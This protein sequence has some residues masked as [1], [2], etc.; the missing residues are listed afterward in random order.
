MFK[1]FASSL[2]LASILIFSGFANIT[3]SPGD[4]GTE[5]IVIGTVH[6]ATDNYNEDTLISILENIKPDII[7]V[8][9]DTSYMTTAF[10]FKESIK[11]ISLETKAITRYQASTPVELRPYDIVNRDAFLDDYNRRNQERNFFREVEQLYSAGSLSPEALA[12]MER[13]LNMMEIAEHM[14]NAAPSYINRADGSSYIDTINYYSYI[15]I[16][17]LIDAAPQLS[18]YKQYWDTEYEFW[19][20]RNNVMI[21]NIIKYKNIYPGKKIVV[22]C[23]FAHRNLLK[24]ALA[25]K[26]NEEE[27]ALREYW[28]Y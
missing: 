4:K 28:E 21:S 3:L 27:I 25:K 15:G 12:K 13:I 11:D 18:A 2:A 10:Q 19:V 23:G 20:E 7:L 24:T 5:I 17:K 9:C 16:S 22:L 6:E 8:E 14:I 1:F 26:A